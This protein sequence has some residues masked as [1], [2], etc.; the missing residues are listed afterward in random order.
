VFNLITYYHF[1]DERPFMAE[2]QSLGNACERLLWRKQTLKLDESAK[3]CD[4]RPTLEAEISM[5]L[6]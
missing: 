4:P 3:I 6:T 5:A 2:L 1:I